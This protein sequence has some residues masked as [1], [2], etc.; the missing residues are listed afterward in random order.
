M[1][2]C[3]CLPGISHRPVG[4]VKIVFEY[5]NRLVEKGHNVSIVFNC[6]DT[7]KK[8]N[9]PNNFREYLCRYIVKRSP[10]WF[11]LNKKVKKICAFGIDNNT[12]PDADIIVA[13]AITTAKDVYDLNQKKRKKAYLIQD[14][15]NWDNTDSDVYNTYQFNMHNIVIS[16]WLK[17]IVDKKSDYP[18][19]YIPNGIDFSVFGIDTPIEER[20]PYSISMLYH[21]SEHKGSK[22]GIEVI[23]ELK[24]Q[25]P[26]LKANL[27]GV[28]QRPKDLPSWINYTRSATQEQLRYIYNESSIFLCSTVKEGFGLTGAESMA[29]GCAL[30]STSYKG[31]LEYAEDEKNALLSPPKDTKSLVKQVK[32]LICDNNLRWKIANEGKE[33]ITKLSWD[34]SVNAFE[35][36]LEKVLNKNL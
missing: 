19:T 24:K 15:E 30:V 18:S 36:E 25:F 8:Y 29:C 11:E 26:E 3:F 7:F 20:N 33:N 17:D 31:V 10:K 16:K 27:F 32:R 4:G 14:F 23:T 35:R 1:N 21:K 6:K 28:P 2:I 22:Y 5:S 12:I 13:T 34:N 9:L